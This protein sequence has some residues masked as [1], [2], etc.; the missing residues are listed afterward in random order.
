MDWPLAEL[1]HMLGSYL[2][3]S[4]YLRFSFEV[5][6]IS[7]QERICEGSITTLDFFSNFEPH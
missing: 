3:I 4:G 6:A 5:S 2:G 1:G 7:L